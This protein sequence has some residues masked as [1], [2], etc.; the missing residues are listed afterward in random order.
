[1][2]NTWCL[3]VS[4][5]ILQISDIPEIPNIPAI[6]DVLDIPDILLPH[7]IWRS[8]TRALI[9]SVGWDSCNQMRRILGLLTIYFLIF[10]SAT[11]ST[12]RMTFLMKRTKLKQ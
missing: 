8:V 1:M 5:Y 12:K 2:Y 3:S 4:P 7:K 6:P 9:Q 11:N 10:F